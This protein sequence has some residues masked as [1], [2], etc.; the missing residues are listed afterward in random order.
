MQAE[1]VCDFSGIHSVWQILFVRKDK[2]DS[3]PK[4]ILHSRREAT[5]SFRSF[6]SLSILVY[7]CFQG[8]RF[9]RTYLLDYMLPYHVE[10]TKTPQ[11]FLSSERQMASISE[12]VARPRCS[13]FSSLGTTYQLRHNG[14]STT[15][16]QGVRQIPLNPSHHVLADGPADRHH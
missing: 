14:Q 16:W 9:A 2:Q 7:P 11:S 12:L 13:S 8:A 4:L 6:L 3:V 15:I 5:F 10:G 1:L